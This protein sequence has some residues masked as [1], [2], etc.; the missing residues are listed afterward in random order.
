[1]R[2]S[3]TIC[4]LVATILAVT[5]SA[6][7]SS[8]VGATNTSWPPPEWRAA[9]S[10]VTMTVLAPKGTQGLHAARAASSAIAQDEATVASM[11]GD[12]RAF[13]LTGCAF[14]V[15]QTSDGKGHVLY[16]I[17]LERDAG[18]SCATGVAYFFRGRTLLTS[19][20]KLAPHAGV[21]TP[22]AAHHRPIIKAAGTSQFA[23]AYEVNRSARAICAEYGAG[24]SITYVYRWTGSK[25]LVLA[26]HPPPAPKA[27][28]P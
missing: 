17:D 21:A 1:L 13:S 28:A 16:A 26:G 9:A 12:C 11:Y 5:M 7:A 3:G 8:S 10:E 15:A 14:F 23:V 4:K 18:D 20:P 2:A 22:Y 19:T 6:A 27:L 24:G 25:M